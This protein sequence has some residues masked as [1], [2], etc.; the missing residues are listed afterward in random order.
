MPVEG[1]IVMK[2]IT[3]CV[4]D[5]TYRKARMW[6]AENDGS[7]SSAVQYMLEHIH[8]ILFRNK[9]RVKDRRSK[10]RIPTTPPTSETSG[11]QRKTINS[12]VYGEK[13]DPVTGTVKL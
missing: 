3:V 2:N 1:E 5:E 10:N 11:S 13:W 4:S 12:I 8:L 6:A 9:P 7:L